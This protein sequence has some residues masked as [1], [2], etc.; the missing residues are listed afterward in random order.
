MEFKELW[1]QVRQEYEHQ[2]ST[3][4]DTSQQ[5]PEEVEEGNVEYKLQLINKSE[6]TV[7]DSIASN[8][9]TEIICAD[10]FKQLIT[11]LHWRLNEGNGIAFY[12]VGVMDNGEAV[13]IDEQSM[14]KSLSTLYQ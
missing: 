3:R 14:Q 10:R 7:K 2:H 11:Q 5:L 9:L 13:G 6:G 8:T 1:R 4:N 12:E